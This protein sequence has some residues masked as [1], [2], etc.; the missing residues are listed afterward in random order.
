MHIADFS[1]GILGANEWS[2][3]FP[4]IVGAGLSIKLRKTDQWRLFFS[5]TELRTG[6]HSTRPVNMA[7]YGSCP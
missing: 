4:I 1:I 6:G 7:P 2:R 5:E 3:G